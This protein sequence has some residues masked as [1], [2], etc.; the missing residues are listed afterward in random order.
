MITYSKNYQITPA[1]SPS[2]IAFIMEKSKKVL[3]EPF[4]H[5]TDIAAPQTP[6]SHHDYYSNGD[7]WWP[8]PDTS[9]GLPYIRKDGVSNPNNFHAHRLLLRRMRTNLAY[10]AAAYKLSGKECFARYGVQLIKEFFLD[11][12]TKMNPNLSY[13]QAIPGICS[14]RGIGIIDTLHLVD[15]PYA[16]EVLRASD[17]MS[18]EIYTSLKDWFAAYLGWMLT[19]TNGIKEM[20]E[21]NNHSVCFFVQA[22][23]FALF[24][25]NERI[26]DF[27]RET[28]KKYLLSQMQSDGSFP[29]EL[30][31]TKPYSYSIFVLDN[32]VTLCHILSNEKDNLWEYNLPNGA[33]IQKGIAF[34]TPYLLNKASWPYAKDI[35]H[36]SAFP[37]RCSFMQFAGY[38]L[39]DK[40]L[41]SLY[42]AL[43]QDILD[44]EARRNIAIRLPFLWL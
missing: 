26:V 8:N 20:T 35:E 40:K 44:E 12:E 15:V 1:L 7:Y 32:M 24:T 39:D 13:A 19:S 30:L 14:G 5:I 27:C 34:L 9:D 16:I 33:N 2:E 6:G 3:E 22:A 42:D 4:V 17:A 11:K 31:R 37:A 21:K 28:Y 10:V 18:E 36:F 25:E 41:L 29:L 43:P 23:V 38:T